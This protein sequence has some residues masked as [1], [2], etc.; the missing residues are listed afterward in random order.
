MKA[1]LEFATTANRRVYEVKV[2]ERRFEWSN[3]KVQGTLGIHIRWKEGGYGKHGT[4][5]ATL[6]QDNTF[7]IK[8][9][10]GT[11]NI[12]PSSLA[13]LTANIKAEIEKVEHASIINELL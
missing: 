4:M 11:R 8:R 7:D 9:W 1:Q 12:A 13:K 5:H 10:T 3:K 2:N 6:L